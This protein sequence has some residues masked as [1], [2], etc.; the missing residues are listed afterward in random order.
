MAAVRQAWL[1]RIFDTDKNVEERNLIAVFR[2]RAVSYRVTTVAVTREAD[3]SASEQNKQI[4]NRFRAF[5]AR[6]R[7]EPGIPFEPDVAKYVSSRIV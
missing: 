2:Y 4:S 1:S 5:I 7:S 6:I 3:A